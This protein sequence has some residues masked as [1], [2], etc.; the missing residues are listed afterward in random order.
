[1]SLQTWFIIIVQM[2]KS[3][4]KRVV[5]INVGKLRNFW[6]NIFFIFIYNVSKRKGKLNGKKGKKERKWVTSTFPLN[7]YQ[8]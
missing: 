5:G 1:M 2:I 8:S 7:I 3:K 4:R 6:F